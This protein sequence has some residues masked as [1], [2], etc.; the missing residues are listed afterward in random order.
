MD[1]GGE[2]VG[3]LAFG[4]VAHILQ[5]LTVAEFDVLRI[6]KVVVGEGKVGKDAGAFIVR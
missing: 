6:R 3:I 1:T 4:I 2:P 5:M